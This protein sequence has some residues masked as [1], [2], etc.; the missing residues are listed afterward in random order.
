MKSNTQKLSLFV[1]LIITIILA[2]VVPV[3]SDNTTLIPPG[4]KT[5]LPDFIG[6]PV[7]SQPLSNYQ[8]PQNPSLAPNPYNQV[9]SDSWQSDIA[10]IISPLGRDPAVLSSTMVK[11][12]VNPNSTTFQ[13]GIFTFDSH[14]RPIMSCL[15]PGEASIVMADPESLDVLSAYNLV[16]QTG[17]EGFLKALSNVYFYLDNQDQFVT[18]NGSHNILTLKEGGTEKNPVLEWANEYDLSGV[19]AVD[20]RLRG[21]NQDWSGRIWFVTGGS[22]TTPGS[23]GVLNP[24]TYPDVKYVRLDDGERISNTFALTKTGAYVVSSQ[25]MYRIGVDPDDQPYV[26][27]SEPYDTIGEI[28]PG[29]YSLGSGTSPTILGNGSYVAITD[30]DDPMK[31]VVFRTDE[32]LEPNEKRIVCEVPVFENEAGGALDNSLVGYDLSLIA[33]NNYNYSFNFST[34]EMTPNAPG[35]ERVDIEPVGSDCNCRKIWTN[36]EVASD[37]APKMSTKTGLIYTMNRKYDEQNGVYVYYWTA[38]DFRTGETV[39]EKMAGT[40]TA[41]DNYYQG[42]GIGPRGILYA[43]SYGGLL[44]IRDTY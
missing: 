29:Q 13:C 37:M 10:D 41:F 9:H 12:R 27:W 34:Q 2:L 5:V 20:D 8:I 1:A 19:I 30:N 11:A 39:W 6:K 23:V 26:V 16:Q 43:G 21:I 7:E 17:Q 36:T 24:K 44:S 14:G 28:K 18:V 32:Q 38:I 33:E 4:P 3:T 42:L 40:G 22:N 31:V 15:G 35:F 25:K